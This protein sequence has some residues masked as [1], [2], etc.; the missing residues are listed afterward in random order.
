M[1]KKYNKTQRKAV[2][3]FRAEFPKSERPPKIRKMS[4]AQRNAAYEFDMRGGKH[5]SRPQDTI[6]RK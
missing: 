4:E 2:K 3:K 6:K 5:F 1:P